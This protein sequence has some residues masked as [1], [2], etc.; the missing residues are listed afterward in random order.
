VYLSLG[1]SPTEARSFTGEIT[2]PSG[3][4]SASEDY[5]QRPRLDFSGFGQHHVGFKSSGI[6]LSKA[7][8]KYGRGLKMSRLT[9]APTIASII[10]TV[11]PTTLERFD[12]LPVSRK[13][14]I[15]VP[16]MAGSPQNL[17]CVNVED[18]FG[19]KAFLVEAWAIPHG[20][21][22]Q[23]PDPGSVG[24]WVVVPMEPY[25]IGLIFRQDSVVIS[26]GWP[27]ATQVVLQG[28]T[29]MK[30]PTGN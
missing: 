26:K 28:D 19:D 4:L 11:Y 27:E 10:A 1:Y 12:A 20:T 3:E 15:V 6:G 9:S 5:T 16:E 7:G 22:L 24:F 2:I 13:T 14:D 17:K 21:N 8:S 29:T 18:R 30:A 23:V 25:E